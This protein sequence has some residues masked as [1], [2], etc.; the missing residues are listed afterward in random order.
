PGELP[1]SEQAS[2]PPPEIPNP[3]LDDPHNIFGHRSPAATTAIFWIAVAFSA[4]QIY[5]AAYAPLSS[6]VMRSLHVGF[7]M[8]LTFAALP[9]LRRGS[10]AS[11]WPGWTLAIVGFALG[12]YQ[13]V[14]E[15][16][17]ILRSGE[18]TTLD[19]WVGIIVLALV[20]EAA[21]RVMGPA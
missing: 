20:F 7:L 12:F 6:L 5:T 17:L 10:K 3:V 21:R 19:L 16:E 13:W 2:S 8:L 18:L 11:H 9:T 4:Y 1:M 14:F 15:E